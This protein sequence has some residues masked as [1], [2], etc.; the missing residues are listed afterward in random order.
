MWSPVPFCE[1]LAGFQTK[2]SVVSLNV[3]GGM[4]SYILPVPVKLSAVDDPHPVAINSKGLSFLHILFFKSEVA[5][6]AAA[7]C[8]RWR[9]TVHPILC[10]SPLKIIQDPRLCHSTA[11]IYFCKILFFVLQLISSLN[12]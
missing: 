6:A 8:G 4:S 11:I 2:T 12:L 3:S 7:S 9:F 5:A 1:Q 10:M